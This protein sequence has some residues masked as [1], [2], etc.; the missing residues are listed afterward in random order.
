MELGSQHWIQSSVCPPQQG[1]T[2]VWFGLQSCCPLLLLLQALGNR[3]H[4]SGEFCR[5]TH[6]ARYHFVLSGRTR[7]SKQ[8]HSEQMDKTGSEVTP[9]LPKIRNKRGLKSNLRLQPWLITEDGICWCQGGRKQLLKSHFL[10]KVEV[11]TQVLSQCLVSSRELNAKPQIPG[12]EV[13]K[14]PWSA[15]WDWWTLPGIG[16]FWSCTVCWGE[17]LCPLA[18][19]VLV[20]NCQAGGCPHLTW[21]SAQGKKASSLLNILKKSSGYVPEN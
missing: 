5:Q 3:W 16:S 18:L 6:I 1:S 4:I 10:Q 7:D 21:V 11:N 14:W 2:Q 9:S 19:S 13:E 8:I 20:I 17:Q 15:L 12:T